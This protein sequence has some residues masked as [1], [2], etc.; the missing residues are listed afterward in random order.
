MFWTIRIILFVLLL[1]V[2][3]QDLKWRE[4]HWVIIPFLAILLILYS[5]QENTLID[6]LNNSLINLS[7]VFIQ[8]LFVTFWFS[9]KSKKLINILRQ[10]IG[11]GDWLFFV[12]LCL[13]FSPINFILFLVSAFILS[14]LIYLITL[15]ILKSTEKTV[16]LAGLVATILLGVLI[17]E[18]VFYPGKLQNDSYITN[19]LG[20]YNV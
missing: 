20:F 1:I 2:V 18:S 15:L 7:I 12:C 13:A 8:F 14:L 4:I 16:P 19:L 6:V 3:Y 10:H 17:I 9:I 5:I 11:L